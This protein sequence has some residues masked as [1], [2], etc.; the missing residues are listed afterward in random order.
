MTCFTPFTVEN[1]KKFHSDKQRV[2]CTNG[3]VNISV[4]H[5]ED[6]RPHTVGVNHYREHLSLNWSRKINLKS[7]QEKSRVL[8]PIQGCTGC[9][10]CYLLT[11]L[12]VYDFPFYVLVDVWPQNEPPGQALHL[13]HTNVTLVKCLQNSLSVWSGR[14]LYY[15]T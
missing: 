11:S 1:V 2:R 9:I 15:L 7:L 13:D 5:N 8:L 6:F 3:F 14:L 4:L 10:I 12:T